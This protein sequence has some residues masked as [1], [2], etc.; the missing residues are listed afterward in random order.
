MYLANK[1]HD[2]KKLLETSFQVMLFL[3][4]P[5][6]NSVPEGVSR[7]YNILVP[8]LIKEPGCGLPKKRYRLLI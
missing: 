5:E 7:F 8:T 4:S 3:V 6:F 1:L 2:P